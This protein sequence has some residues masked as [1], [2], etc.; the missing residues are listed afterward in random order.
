MLL[1][2]CW[3]VFVSFHCQPTHLQTGS[4]TVETAY[5]KMLNA[6]LP[7]DIRVLAWAPVSHDFS[8]R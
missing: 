7:E 6:V 1:A 2:V 5:V 4:K 3:C 8:A